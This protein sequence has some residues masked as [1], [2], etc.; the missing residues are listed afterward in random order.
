MTVLSVGTKITS[1]LPIRL[2]AAACTSDGLETGAS[3]T[4]MKLFVADIF[5]KRTS[6]WELLSLGLNRRPIL[7]ASGVISLMRSNCF[8]IGARSLIPVV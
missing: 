8:L 7:R 6:V 4:V 3:T 5:I 1:A 2:V